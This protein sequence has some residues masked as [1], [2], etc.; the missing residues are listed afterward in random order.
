LLYDQLIHVTSEFHNILFEFIFVEDGSID[1]SFSTLKD[2]SI[3]DK[4][5]K[6][7]KFSRNFGSFIACFAGIQYAK[8]DCIAVIAADLQDPPLLLKSFHHKWKL[9]NDVVL[10]VRSKRKDSFTRGFFS[11]LFYLSFKFFVFPDFPLGGV[12]SFLIDKRVAKHLTEMQEKN[13]SLIGQIFWLGF[14]RDYVYYTKER[15]PFGKS[16]WSFS[17]KVKYFLDSLLSL[18]YKPIRCVSYAGI[19]IAT[20]GFIYGIFAIYQKLVSHV[21]I[22]GFT[23]IISILIFS[24]GFQMIILGVIGEYIWRNLEE[25]RHRPLFVIDEKIGFE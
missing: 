2:L 8:G 6:I 15:R 22:P 23:T 20:I 7:I 19:M 24:S 25:S 9:G 18:S 3:K 16:K 14:K 12:D 4:R 13:S 1:D 5:V 17:K 11:K 10:A 21:E